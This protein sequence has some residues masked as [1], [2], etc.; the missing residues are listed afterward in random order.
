M[1]SAPSKPV[2][3]TKSRKPQVCV[4]CQGPFK[5]PVIF[6]GLKFCRFCFSSLKREALANPSSSKEKNRATREAKSKTEEGIEEKK[7]LCEEHGEPL[8]WFCTEE[9]IPLCEICKASKD[10]AS[11]SMVPAEDA[12][13]EYK[14]K[15]QRAVHLLERHLDK[16]LKLKYQE[17]KKT[18]EWKNA[19]HGQKER[20]ENEFFKLHT[21]LVEEEERLL[22]RL[23]K[24]KQETLKKLHS[25]LEQLS[26]QSSALK[27]LVT[28]VKE[29]SRQPAGELLKD[30]DNTLSRSE[31]VTVQETEAV[32]TMLK[33]VYNI[34]C[35]DIIDILTEFKADVSLDP[36]TAHPG[37]VLSED[38]KA[39]KY[40]GMQQGP[41]S[42]D[43]PEKFD[44]YIL[45]LGSERFT[46][47]RHYWEVEVG[48]SPEWDL[49]ICRES[50]NRK[51]LRTMFSPK[52]GFW[53]LWLRDGDRYKVLISQPTLLSLGMKPTRVGVF[54]DYEEGEVSFYNVTEKTHIYTYIGTFYTPL[55]PFFS[56]CR[57]WKGEN[58]CSLSVCPKKESVRSKNQ[59][60]VQVLNP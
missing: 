40:G 18:A 47:G 39:V 49:G 31:N 43:N 60:S 35:I 48:D 1:A 54:L 21:F 19:V 17:G 2:P 58:A 44:A 55:R 13:L 28:E 7:G 57:H 25:N 20:I 53:R 24:E 26:G 6:D 46:S 34:P 22:K 38:R 12:A 51:G 42:E 16:S 52:S 41:P 29:K 15:L 45:V 8:T 50:V 56:P 5:N 10:H 59:S 27:Q 30:V 11:H 9:R 3:K 23:K 32:P 36:A 33:H 14:G 4:L 37:L